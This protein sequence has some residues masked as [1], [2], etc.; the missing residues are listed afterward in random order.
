VPLV[1]SGIARRRHRLAHEPLGGDELRHEFFDG[2]WAEAPPRL[3]REAR[4]PLLERRELRSAGGA[5]PERAWP[6]E[7][8]SQEMYE[9]RRKKDKKDRHSAS[10]R[11]T[12][13]T[14]RRA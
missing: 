1:P 3:A 11:L 10:I 4:A 6:G 8:E 5:V 7:R 9:R 2:V 12:S 14:T 13:W